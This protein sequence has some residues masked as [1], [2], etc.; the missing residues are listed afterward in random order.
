MF[1]CFRCFFLGFCF[2]VFFV[3]YFRDFT[4]CTWK[5]GENYSG[6]FI[7]I[8]MWGNFRE[9]NGRGELLCL[10]V[11]SNMWGF[12]RFCWPW[13]RGVS[14]ISINWVLFRQITYWYFRDHLFSS[15]ENHNQK[16]L[17]VWRSFH[18]VVVILYAWYAPS[19][20]DL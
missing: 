1:I 9:K 3:Y 5:N 8:N 12:F 10:F 7:C 19:Y 4:K 20:N 17:C 2:D 11:Y 16:G 13:P 14:K 15:F 6:V 18:V